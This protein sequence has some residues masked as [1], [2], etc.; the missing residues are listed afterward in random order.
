MIISKQPTR[1]GIRAKK[2]TFENGYN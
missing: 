2:E 1:G